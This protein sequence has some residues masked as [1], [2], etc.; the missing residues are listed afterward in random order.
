[1]LRDVAAA[2]RFG[3][4]RGLYDLSAEDAGAPALLL[5]VRAVLD[6]NVGHHVGRDC[7]AHARTAYVSPQFLVLDHVEEEIAAGPAV[8]LGYR[9]P[10]EPGLAALRQNSRGVPLPSF[11]HRR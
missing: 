2:S 11:S 10:D 3:E 4:A 6:E 1:M 7:R 9:D 5:F 8:F